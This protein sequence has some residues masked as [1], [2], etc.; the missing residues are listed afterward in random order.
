MLPGPWQGPTLRHR[1]SPGLRQVPQSVH[2]GQQKVSVTRWREAGS[3]CRGLPGTP[4]PLGAGGR[5]VCLATP[6]AQGPPEKGQEPPSGLSPLTS[7]SRTRGWRRGP[8][9]SL[10]LRGVCLPVCPRHS[11]A[12]SPSSAPHPVR[13]R[14]PS[15]DR[16]LLSTTVPPPPRQPSP[17]NPG[18]TRSMRTSSGS[19]NL[20]SC[21]PPVPVLPLPSSPAASHR[22]RLIPNTVFSVISTYTITLFT[23]FPGTHGCVF[24]SS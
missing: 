8:L 3:R 13:P 7:A 20:H 1:W 24:R 9:F 5:S 22:L 19:E 14:L 18:G 23:Q 4:R 10:C 16:F 2:R 6:E 12:P 17:T 15:Q 11:G 21:P